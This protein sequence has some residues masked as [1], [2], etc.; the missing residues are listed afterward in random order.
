MAVRYWPRVTR[1]IPAGSWAAAGNRFFKLPRPYVV[2]IGAYTGKLTGLTLS[3][4]Q[5]A[6]IISAGGAVTVSVG[7]QGLGTLWYPGQVTISTTTGPLD[8]ATALIYLGNG[9]VP[10]EL[11][12][13]VYTGNG[14]AGLAVP[15]MQPGDLIIVQWTGGHPGDIAALNIVG[16]MDALTTGRP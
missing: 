3:G 5:N 2:P 14:T 11:L 15:P 1:A 9:G 10:T 7:P 12:A 8:G 16:T 4:G 6:G 13:T